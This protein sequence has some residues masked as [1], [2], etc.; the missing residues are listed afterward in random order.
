MAAYRIG[1]ERK[2]SSVRSSGI[3]SK[4]ITLS[5]TL[6]S[7]SEPSKRFSKKYCRYMFSN[8]VIGPEYEGVVGMASTGKTSLNGT[9]PSLKS[10]A[11]K[12]AS[13]FGPKTFSPQYIPRSSQSLHGSSEFSYTHY[14]YE[15]W[16][17]KVI[18]YLLPLFATLRAS[19]TAGA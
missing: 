18:W 9:E 5:C 14:Q 17:E 13:V 2:N 6:K 15:Y 8:A 10:P 19:S 3:I 11:T 7:V 16:L 4:P 1:G 12:P